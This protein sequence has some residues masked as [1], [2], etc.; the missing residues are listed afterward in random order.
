MLLWVL[1]HKFAAV[2]LKVGQF[3]EGI[4]PLHRQLTVAPWVNG[5]RYR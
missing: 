1:V 2:L 4:E 3:I 5:K